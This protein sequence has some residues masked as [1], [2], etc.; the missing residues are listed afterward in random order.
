MNVTAARA[1]VEAVLEEFHSRR[2]A[3][4]RAQSTE[5]LPVT[6]SEGKSYFASW[7]REIWENGTEGSR[8]RTT[9]PTG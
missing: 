7:Y 4:T 8:E 9:G 5:V 3:A 1:K 2:H 6:V